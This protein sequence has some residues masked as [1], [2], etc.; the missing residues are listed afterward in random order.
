MHLR[1]NSLAA[2]ACSLILAPAALLIGCADNHNGHNHGGSA[3]P[4]GETAVAEI[5]P[6]PA[7]GHDSVAG[8]VTF[9]QLENNRMKVTARVTGLDPNGTH[10][11]HIHETGDLSA[12]DFTS[13]GGHYNPEGH[14]H[15]APHGGEVHAGDLGNLKANADGVATYEMIVDDLT[16]DGDVNPIVGKPVIIHAK[17]DDLK[18]QP[19]GDAGPR[20][21][22]GIIRKR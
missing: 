7:P 14:P 17:A 11:F 1:L 6:S 9:T 4:T 19:S 2:A 16:I 8:R 20:I 3:V 12:A 15:G 10:G 22:G 5:M 21:G 13:A 18:S